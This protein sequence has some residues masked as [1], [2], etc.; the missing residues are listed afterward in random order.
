MNKGMHVTN[1]P[2]LSILQGDIDNQIYTLRKKHIRL[3]I[4]MANVDTSNST[5]NDGCWI[6]PGIVSSNYQL[7]PSFQVFS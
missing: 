5:S 7:Q 6:W 4:N 3:E 2:S 1:Y